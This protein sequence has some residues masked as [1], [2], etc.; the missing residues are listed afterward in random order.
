MPITWII[1]VSKICFAT[2]ADIGKTKLKKFS[3][4]TIFWEDM[5]GYGHYGNRPIPSHTTVAAWYNPLNYLTSTPPYNNHWHFPQLTSFSSIHWQ[6]HIL[7]NS[8]WPYFFYKNIYLKKK[9]A[10]HSWLPI[11]SLVTYH[12]T[13]NYSYIKA[14]SFVRF[15]YVHKI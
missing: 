10:L 14:V 5:R 15:W 3:P 2:A 12:Y 1:E 11:A 8:F 6:S 9:K 13:I 7:W 4:R